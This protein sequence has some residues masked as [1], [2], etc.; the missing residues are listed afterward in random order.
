MEFTLICYFPRS[1]HLFP[2]IL[3]VDVSF[4]TTEER[5]GKGKLLSPAQLFVA[6]WTVACTK[7]LCPWDFLGKNTGVGC[8]VLLQGI[9]LT[10]GPNPGLPH[11]RQTLYHL[12]H[13]GNPRDVQDTLS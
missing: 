10:Q 1:K 7:L 13:Q 8:R 12:S 5:K 6:P 2:A 3:L 11:C 9:S 4:T